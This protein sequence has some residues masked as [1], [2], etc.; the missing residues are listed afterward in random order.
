MT[1]NF[2]A[3]VIFSVV[4]A[5]LLVIGLFDFFEI[6]GYTKKLAVILAVCFLWGSFVIEFAHNDN[7]NNYL[8]TWHYEQVSR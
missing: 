6:T 4:F 7:K 5:V 2:I 8:D 1:L 3:G